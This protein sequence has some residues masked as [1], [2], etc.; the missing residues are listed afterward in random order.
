MKKKLIFFI[1][2]ILSCIFISSVSIFASYLSDKAE[3]PVSL[4]NTGARS[5]CQ[6]DDGYVWIGQFA[7]LNRYD[8]KELVSYNSFVDSDGE[9][10]SIENVKHLS[11]YENTLFLVCSSGLVKME[12]NTFRRI[13][14]PDSNVVINDL[15]MND[16]GL[17][18]ICSTVGLYTYNLDNDSLNKD[19]KHPENIS[20]IAIYNNYR[21]ILKNDSIYD[22]DDKLIYNGNNGNAVNSAC[23]F[24]DKLAIATKTGLIYFYDVM[25]NLMMDTVINLKDVSGKKGDMV[26]RFVYS[27]SDN[28]LFAACEKGLYSINSKTL[29][30]TYAKNL[31]NTDKVVDLMIDYEGNLWIAS[32]ITGVSIISKSSLVDLLFDI[33]YKVMPE[34]QRLVYAI[35]KDGNDLYMATEGGIYVYDIKTGNIKTNHPLVTKINEIIEY[36]EQ[37]K[38]EIDSLEKRKVGYAQDYNKLINNDIIFSSLGYELKDNDVVLVLNDSKN[39]NIEYYEY[40]V[41]GPGL[42]NY[43]KKINTIPKSKVIVNITEKDDIYTSKCE[44][45][46]RIPW[47]DVR[48]IEKYK[49]K[50]YFATYGSG[51][52]EY[53]PVTEEFRQYRGTD[54]NPS[55]P[56]VNSN[57]YY[58]VAQRCLNANDDY[59]FIGTATN[60][61]IR[62][63]GTDFIYNDNLPI[64]GAQ[65]LYIGESSFGKVT[66]VASA[67]GIYTINENLEAGSFESI[68]GIEESTSGIL[69]FYQDGDYFYYNIY[70]RLFVIDTN[71]DNETIEIKIPYV[72]S[73]ITE[74]NKIKITDG[75]GNI[76]YKYVVASEKQIYIIND[77]LADNLEYEFYDSSNGLKSS[78]KGN[79]SGYYDEEDSIYYFQSQNGVFTYNFKNDVNTRVPLKIQVNSVKVDD[80]NII[81]DKIIIDKYADRV[82]FNISVLSFKPTKGY[83]VYYKLEGVDNE[84]IKLSDSQL[85]VSYTNLSGGS[86]QFSTY[87]IDENGQL[88]NEVTISLVKDKRVYETVWFWVLIIILALLLIGAINFLI[89]WRRSKQAKKRESELKEITIESIEAIARTID[90]KDTYT[91]G[92]SIRVGHYSRIIAEELGMEGDEL[93][94]LYYTALLHD[95]GKIGIPDAILNKPGRLTDEE[96][97]IMK[98]H[99]TKGAKILKDIST[100]PNIVEGAKYHH[101]KYGGGGYPEGLK[102]EDI[103]YIARIICC[104]DCFDAMATRRVYKDPYPKEKI[105]SEFER[106]KE[107]QFDPKIADVV[108]KLIEEGKLKAE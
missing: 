18:Y 7:G 87:V 43:Y 77:L 9:K 76:T 38:R 68:P 55:D 54:I 26:H 56:D 103:P 52:L 25:N 60:S 4:N 62:F 50:I 98:S 14:F 79:S 3:I 78:I 75:D 72:N 47:Y 83:S 86:Y 33:D 95:I 69:K 89:I 16:S 63:D 94:N 35:L 30:A 85:S 92:H 44:Y 40:H 6:T 32:Y 13:L 34:D 24:N 90:A 82:T 45:D 97:D 46:V 74:I 84:Y 17:L 12:N 19:E 99:T 61:I 73:S 101:E 8:S 70:G 108:I 59:L 23:Y 71:N 65:I 31:E 106:C 80:K 102:G 39:E 66:F 1:S 93:E 53:D 37:K 81:G 58:A 10:Y 67:N 100:I 29:E 15:V 91:N 36:D 11:S 64:S 27:S 28:D 49:G 21:Y 41:A 20:S 107:I 96:F 5:I 2:I 104:A 88:S 42:D 51:L 48:D 57:G 22:Y 105:I